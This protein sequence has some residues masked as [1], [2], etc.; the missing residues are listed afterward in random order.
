MPEEQR[1]EE[2]LLSQ[3]AEKRISNELDQVEKIDV[4]VQTNLFKVMQG[5]TDGVSV[6]GKGLVKEGIRVQ[7]IK[8]KTDS[9]GVNPLSAL[10]GQIELNHAVN[11]SARVVMTEADINHALTSD[12]VRSKFQKFDLN[13]DGEIVSLQPQ[14]IQ[15]G[16]PGDGKMAFAGKVLLTEKGNSRRVGFTAIARPRKGQQPIMLESFTCIEGDGFPLEFVVTL[17]EKVKELVNLPY[18][19]YEGTAIRVQNMEVE[20]GSLTLLVDTRLKEIPSL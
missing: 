5:E 11:A 12:Y 15:I 14:V 10:F 7:E 3:E 20:K 8:L 18:F 4:D 13:V 17:M 16:L 2:Q 19:Q 6:T 1:L 9:L